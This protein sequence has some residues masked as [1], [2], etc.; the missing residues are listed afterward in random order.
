MKDD[1]IELQALTGTENGAIAELVKQMV[2]QEVHRG[3]ER[4]H[5]L[6]AGKLEV[7]DVDPPLPNHWVESVDALVELA[8]VNSCVW[9]SGST[10][11]LD[12]DARPEAHRRGAVTWKLTPTA[13]W[14]AMVG[15]SGKNFDQKGAIRLLTVELRKA[16]TDNLAAQALLGAIRVMRFTRTE[17]SQS[18]VTPGKASMGREIMAEA[19]GV[20]E[21]PEWLGLSVQRW[22]E[23]PGYTVPV[24]LRVE[25]DPETGV[26]ELGPT[27]D[28]VKRA[29]LASQDWLCDQIDAALADRMVDPGEPTPQLPAVLVGKPCWV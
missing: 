1:L 28:E 21:I 11:V 4:R 24:E 29:E 26:F 27:S 5:V 18:E 20:A 10:A 16:T 23:Y 7:F 15:A 6:A 13:A 22:A 8:T 14:Q 25:V 9:V 12:L 3:T 19:R 17:N 2:V